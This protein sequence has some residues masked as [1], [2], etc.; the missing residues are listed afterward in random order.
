M[1]LWVK[2][3]GANCVVN[4]VEF[5]SDL[6]SFDI[7][8]LRRFRVPAFFENIIVHLAVIVR[9]EMPKNQECT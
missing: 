7:R 5:P 4:G 2:V 3:V 6:I 1:I 9:L 8:Y